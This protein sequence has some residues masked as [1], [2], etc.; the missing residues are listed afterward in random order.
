M[1]KSSCLQKLLSSPDYFA[2]KV[3]RLALGILFIFVGVKKFRMGY[4]GF[5]ESLVTADTLMAKEIPNALLY[6]YGYILPALEFV[7]GVALVAGKYVKES[8]VTI[9][10]I[11]LSFVFGQMYNGNTSKIGT[12]YFPSLLV[13]VMAYYA[14]H[15][16]SSVKE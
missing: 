16:V 9:A 10:F 5:A 1:K 11:Y 12:E 15:K 7:V 8:Y 14:H 4:G 13:L 3:L 6:L 2:A